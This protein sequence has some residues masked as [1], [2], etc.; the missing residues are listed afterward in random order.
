MQ[1]A[2]AGHE[3]LLD[4]ALHHSVDTVVRLQKVLDEKKTEILDDVMQDV[5]RA[6]EL[7]EP[8]HL[9][10]QDHDG[11]NTPEGWQV[12][13][14][15][16]ACNP[17]MLLCHALSGS[18]TRGCLCAAELGPDHGAGQAGECSRAQNGC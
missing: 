18:S 10:Q 2:A 6:A 1:A 8:G 3:P 14:A 7:W 5:R 16:L 17:R 4:R 9:P 12:S 13:A 11:V 15:P